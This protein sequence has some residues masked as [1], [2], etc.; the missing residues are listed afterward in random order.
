VVYLDREKIHC[1]QWNS[2]HEGRLAKVMW[3]RLLDYGKPEWQYM[4]QK[5]PNNIGLR[6]NA[7]CLKLLKG[8]GVHIRL[9]V[10]EIVGRY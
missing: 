7:T 8:F 1:S 4:L 5:K 6:M 9:F 3:E 10:Y 2:W